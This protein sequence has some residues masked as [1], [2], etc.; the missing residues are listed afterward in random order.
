MATEPN[1][2]RKETLRRLR[3]ELVADV[4]LANNLLH[5][6]NRNLDQLRT[7]TS[8]LLRVE[9]LPD[10]PLIKYGF[11]AL[12]RASFSD[13]TNSNN[14]EIVMT[15]EEIMESKDMHV[16]Q[17]FNNIFEG[18]D[19]HVNFICNSSFAPGSSDIRKLAKDYPE[20]Q[21]IDD[22]FSPLKDMERLFLDISLCSRRFMCWQKI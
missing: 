11:S 17:N 6:L 15:S 8:E 16:V 12:E 1:E 10:D 19:K 14:L 4:E 18:K 22:N 13:M 5:E 7:R 3:R 21:Y 20:S 9:A 2:L